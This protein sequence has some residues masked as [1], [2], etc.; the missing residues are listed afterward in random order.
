MAGNQ[1]TLN[2]LDIKK[3]TLTD[4]LN[5]PTLITA[6]TRA[7]LETDLTGPNM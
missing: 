3:L 2:A 5:I 7:W 4:T 6:N 1:T